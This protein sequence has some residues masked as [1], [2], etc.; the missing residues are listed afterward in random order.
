MQIVEVLVLVV[1]IGLL[2]LIGSLSGNRTAD[3]WA[4]FATLDGLKFEW[5]MEIQSQPTRTWYGRVRTGHLY[6]MFEGRSVDVQEHPLTYQLRTTTYSTSYENSKGEHVLVRPAF[7]VFG[8]RLVGDRKSIVPVGAPHFD[9]RFVTRAT[10]PEIV[11]E[12]FGED[13]ALREQLL[14]RHVSEL[15]IAAGQITYKER[16]RMHNADRVKARLEMLSRIAAKL[17]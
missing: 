2:L 14:A 9:Q 7:T 4:S 11:R 6:G 3:N 12:L 15:R 16:S 13:P 8:L 5:T 17:E 10:P 1:M